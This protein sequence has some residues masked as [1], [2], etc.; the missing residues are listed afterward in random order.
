MAELDWQQIY[1]VKV[2][3]SKIRAKVKTQQTKH[4]GVYQFRQKFTL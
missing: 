1:L 4:K 3:V 2:W